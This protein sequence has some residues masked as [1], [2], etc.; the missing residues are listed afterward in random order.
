[1]NI[2][3]IRT[4]ADYKLALKSV[5]K[6]VEADPSPDSREGEFLDVMATLIEAYEAKQ[7][8]IVAPDPIQAIKFRMEQAGLEPKDLAA[9]I[10]KPNRVYEVLNGKRGLSIEMIRKL[11]RNLGIPAE[12]LIG[13]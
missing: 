1:M 11:H 5:S 7:F 8:A 3:P 4:A 6:L 2:S 13:A 12:S 10:G 9:S